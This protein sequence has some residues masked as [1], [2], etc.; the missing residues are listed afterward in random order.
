[1][2]MELWLLLALGMIADVSL[3]VLGLRLGYVK[4]KR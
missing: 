1:M 3:L 2:T 4:R